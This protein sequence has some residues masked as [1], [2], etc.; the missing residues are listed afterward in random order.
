[1]NDRPRIMIVED[2]QIIAMHI[3]TVLS[4]FDYD[5]VE[6]VPT[7][8]EALMLLKEKKPDL[9]FMDIML[10]GDLDGIETAQR[11]K[12]NFDI[13]VVYLTA[14]SNPEILQRAK[15]TEP[16][17]Y[18]VKPFTDRELNIAVEI[19]LYK[20]RAEREL[21]TL[22]GLLPICA[23]CK[24]IRNEE[25]YWQQVEAYIQEHSEAEFTHCLCPECFEKLTPEIS[26]SQ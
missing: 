20:H 14:H 5:V 2:E 9:V 7:G 6:M 1:M 16:Y 18:V 8:E 11:V 10:G 4:V 25:G 26:P 24:K 22:R 21:H 12:E 13:P 19:A 17:G 3:S 23:W 15:I